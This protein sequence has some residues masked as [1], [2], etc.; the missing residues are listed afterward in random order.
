MK[1]IILLA[2]CLLLDS[3]ILAG[4]SNS[5]EPFA[6]K[7]YMSDTQIN[8]IYLDVQDRE[9]EVSLSVDEHVHIIYYENR[10]EYYDISVSGKNVLTMASVNDKF[11]SNFPLCYHRQL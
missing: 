11:S 1:K 6:K 8:E 10:K 5:S 7:R 9:I 2:L 3:F 4:C